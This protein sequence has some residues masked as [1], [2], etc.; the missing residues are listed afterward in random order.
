M[1]F[2]PNIV[3]RDEMM[4]IKKAYGFV[5]KGLF[6]AFSPVV[7]QS[8]D[9]KRWITHIGPHTCAYCLTRNGTVYPINENVDL[10]V[11]NNCH[12]ALSTYMSIVAGNATKDGVNGADYW[13]KHY[14][15]LP[16]YYVSRE[17]YINA[18][19]KSGK[20]PIKWFPDKMMYG[21]VYYNEKGKLPN[22]L[23]RIWYEADI[24]YYEGRR[25]AHRIYFSNDGLI[26]VSYDHGITFYEIV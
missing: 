21:E 24:N 2:C 22:A 10:P 11:H 25:N 26:F 14:G 19:W 18:G 23:N 16:D 6:D 13:L 12:C 20:P 9:W 5:D 17:E 15:K 4:Y 3:K 7:T 1:D 8:S